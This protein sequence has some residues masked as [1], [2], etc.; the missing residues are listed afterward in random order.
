MPSDIAVNL[1]T[2]GRS[3]TGIRRIPEGTPVAFEEKDGWAG[4]R[5]PGLDLHAMYEIAVQK[6]E[7]GD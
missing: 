5:V 2:D 3:V 6:E 1:C 4:F 7:K